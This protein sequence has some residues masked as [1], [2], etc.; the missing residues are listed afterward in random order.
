[1][2]KRHTQLLLNGSQSLSVF[3]FFIAVKLEKLSSHRYVVE[4]GSN[5][6]IALLA[7]MGNSLATDNQKL[8]KGRSANFSFKTTILFQPP[9][10][11][12]YWLSHVTSDYGFF[13]G[14]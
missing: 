3:I 1:M 7:R 4:N 9:P 14:A 8:S 13:V 5:V 10:P 2:V 6:K 12:F 11:S